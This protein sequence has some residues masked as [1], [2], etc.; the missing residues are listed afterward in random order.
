MLRAEEREKT[1][2]RVMRLSLWL[3]EYFFEDRETVRDLAADA[4]A[5][6]IRHEDRFDPDKG[7]KFVTFAAAY[8]ILFMKSRAREAGREAALFQRENENVSDHGL[9]DVSSVAHD[10]AELAEQRDAVA[11]LRKVI[12]PKLTPAARRVFDAILTA[13][14]W[15][16]EDLVKPAQVASVGGVDVYKTA[17]RKAAKSKGDQLLKDLGLNCKKRSRGKHPRP[18][19][20][21]S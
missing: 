19:K 7:I 1:Y 6:V 2:E 21:A 18:P 15:H 12:F 13:D 17:I 3:A 10:P 4:V 11:Y 14:S 16:A 5:Y 8:M 20:T 9:P